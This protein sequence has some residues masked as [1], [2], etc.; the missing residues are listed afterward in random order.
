MPPN[1]YLSEPRGGGGLGG[2]AYKDRGWPPPPPPRDPH[3]VNGTNNNANSARLGASL[4]LY[5]HTYEH[6]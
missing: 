4:S 6:V 2:V 1:H 5:L 3:A